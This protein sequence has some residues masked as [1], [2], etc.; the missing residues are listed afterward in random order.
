MSA[1]VDRSPRTA[2]E[3]EAAR[4]YALVIA[5]SDEDDAYLVSVPDLPRLQTHGATP[6]EAAAMGV[7]AVAVWLSAMRDL[8]EPIPSPLTAREVEF[9]PPPAYDGARIRRLRQRLNLSQGALAQLLNVKP[10]TVQA[11]EQGTRTP[12]G[13]AQRLLSIAEKSP[14]TL[15]RLTGMRIKTLQ[16][17]R[18]SGTRRT[19]CAGGEVTDDALTPTRG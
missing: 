16:H 15:H 17:R 9:E 10:R 12:D 3:L 19:G 8:G 6:E 13:A 4:R 18:A 1:T 14:K 2:E 7:E 5:W 11:W